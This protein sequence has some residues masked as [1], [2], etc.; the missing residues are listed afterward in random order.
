MSGGS[1]NYLYCK[2]VAELFEP[3]NMGLV[4]DMADTLL[5]FGYRDIAR[6]MQRLSEYIKTAYNRVDVLRDQLK[7]V[8]RSVEW[9]ES[10]DYGEDTLKKHLEDYRN[11]KRGE[12]E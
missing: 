9:Y 4:D 12:A 1:Y 3:S 8:M 7:D 11:G 10:C 2:D 5:A 6:D